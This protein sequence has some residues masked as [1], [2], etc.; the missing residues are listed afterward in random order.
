M[1]N[2]RSPMAMMRFLHC[3]VPTDLA[4]NSCISSANPPLFA[5]PNNPR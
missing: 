3:Q 5:L 4:R 2:M 1:Q